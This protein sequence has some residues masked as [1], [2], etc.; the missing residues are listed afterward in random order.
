MKLTFKEYLKEAKYTP[1]LGFDRKWKKDL[2]DQFNKEVTK[3]RY[4]PRVV[5]I[6]E[7]WTTDELRE[8]ISNLRSTQISKNISWWDNPTLLSKIDS[9]NLQR[10][11]KNQLIQYLALTIWNWGWEGTDWFI[12]ENEP[13]I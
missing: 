8:Y 4:R 2:K 13:H 6:L 12:R 1:V 3:H 5:E 7:Q 11:E 9:H 10:M